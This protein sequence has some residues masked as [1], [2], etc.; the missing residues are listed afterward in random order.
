MR[1]SDI[2]I[3]HNQNTIKEDEEKKEK[4]TNDY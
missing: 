3:S 2:F 1:Y 4:T